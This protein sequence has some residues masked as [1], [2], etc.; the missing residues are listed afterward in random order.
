MSDDQ[1][2]PP[3]PGWWLA[4]DGRWYPPQSAPA[5]PPA[6]APGPPVPGPVPGPAAPTKSGKGCL[7]GLGVV[8]AVVVVIGV[9]VAVAIWRFASAVDDVADGVTVGDVNC[10]TAEKVSRHRW[11]AR[12]TGDV[13]RCRRGVGCAY[14]SGGQGPG[15]S[16]V[17]GAGLI[18]D[19][20]LSELESTAESNGTQATSIDEGE[21]GKAFGSAM[22]SEAA[23]KADDHIV[24][25]EIFS[26]GT[27]PIGDKMDEAVEILSLYVDLND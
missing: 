10:P 9:V 17:S 8:G 2:T 11:A 18:S 21:D 25:V 12:R 26:E 23:T 15:V 1:P 6:P 22:R 13:R 24:Q 3:G 20:V 16:I 7:I 19:E 4:S 14:S 5:P 27:D